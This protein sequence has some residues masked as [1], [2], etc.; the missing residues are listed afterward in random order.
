MRVVIA[1]G[2]KIGSVLLHEIYEEGHEVLLIDKKESTIEHLISSEE[3]CGIVGD[4]TSVKVLMEAEAGRA[5]VFI[6]TLQHDEESLL[7]ASL[8]K[9]L[10]AKFVIARIRTPK[11]GH[12]SQLIRESMNIDYV[13]NPEEAT[14]QYIRELLQFS[15]AQAVASFG[16]AGISLITFTIEEGEP[17]DGCSLIDL[18]KLSEGHALV[19]LVQRDD[20]VFVPNGDCVLRAHDKITITGSPQALDELYRKAG[21]HNQANKHCLVI[22]G[23][24]FGYYT[25][26]ALLEIGKHVKVIERD[27]ARGEALLTEL[28][29]LDV[30]CAD[31]SDHDLL[32]EEGLER[33]DAVIALTDID[34]E[35]LLIAF[36]A[37][38]Q[39][40]ERVIAKVNRRRLLSVLDFER[41]H[42]A[43]IV[44][45][46]DVS[47]DLILREIRACSTASGSLQQVYRLAGGEAEAVFAEVKPDSPLLHRSLSELPIK[48]GHLIVA[49]L[50]NGEPL[51][52]K[53]HDILQA[54]DMILLISA[55]KRIP[56]LEAVLEG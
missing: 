3:V 52:P 41:L 5:D 37:G 33:F 2:G 30:I 40:V 11:Y 21:R 25:A 46:S 16:S 47:A 53:G 24:R 51:F 48:P 56:Y 32:D 55:D 17:L 6:A 49:I 36:Y 27:R 43:T 44:T 15:E 38:N 20:N 39:G 42:Q 8:A 19:C 31:G 12:A 13:I 28:P 23:G 29:R 4:A 54:G 18:P 1:G 35:N 34:E 26:R 14:A 22:G 50:R 7:A 10:G 45:P 9:R